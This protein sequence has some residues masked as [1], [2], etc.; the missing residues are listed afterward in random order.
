M[1]HSQRLLDA[2][3][4]FDEMKASSQRSG[5]ESVTENIGHWFEGRALGFEIAANHLWVMAET[6]EMLENLK[7]EKE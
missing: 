3:K 1:K 2:A 5:A 6:A 7:G 4:M